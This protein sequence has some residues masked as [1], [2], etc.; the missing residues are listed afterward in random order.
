MI[1]LIVINQRIDGWEKKGEII[2]NYFN[3]YNLYKKIYIISLLNSDKPSKNTLKTLCGSNKYEFI[4]IRSKILQ[5]KIIKYLF[6]LSFYNNLILKNL[7][8]I[9]LEKPNHVK[10]IGDGFSGFI[11]SII[12][13]YYKTKLF[14]SIHSFVSFKVFFLYMNLKEKINFILERRFTKISHNLAK[15]IF[16]VYDKIKQN[17]SKENVKKIKIIYNDI[18]NS[19]KYEKK[20]FSLKRTVK[21]VYVGRLIKGKSPEI[22]IKSLRN[23][24]N[25]NLSIYGDGPEKYKLKELS[26]K[27]NMTNRVFFKGFRNNKELIKDLRQY[28]VFVFFDKFFEFPKTVMEAIFV[29]LPLIVNK[30]PLISLKEFKGFKIFWVDDCQESYTNMIQN[31]IDNKYNL[32]E[33]SKQNLK[34]IK[35]LV[36]SSNNKDYFKKIVE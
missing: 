33:I 21:L 12:A 3:R 4:K 22:I 9:K 15:H 35:K 30:K 24:S 13:R 11:A 16:I 25:L 28:H 31:I 34:N 7:Q 23:F 29:G 1:V 36:S 5:I 6:P 26:Q 19:K 2:K 20:E 32:K 27:L 18:Y 10:S 17:V 8:N 14:I